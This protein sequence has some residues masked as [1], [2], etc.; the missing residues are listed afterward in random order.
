MI[1]QNECLYN[2]SNDFFSINVDNFPFVYIEMK[3]KTP[4]EEEFDKYLSVLN[5]LHIQ[6]NPLA[7]LMEFMGNTGYLKAEYRIKLGNWTTLNKD[8]MRKHLVGAAFV[9]NSLLHKVLLQGIFFIQTPPY[10]YIV[11]SDI[12][13]AKKW[14]NEKITQIV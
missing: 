1:I 12:E 5:D 9:T 10:E 14:V 8:K 4:T 6:D 13:K 7:I 3:E 2:F 11:V